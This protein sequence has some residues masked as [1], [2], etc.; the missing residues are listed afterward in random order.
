ML[1]T[2]AP[3]GSEQGVKMSKEKKGI[4]LFSG[5]GKGFNLEKRLMDIST[6]TEIQYDDP[7]RAYGAK[8]EKIL[9]EAKMLSSGG[10]SLK[11]IVRAIKIAQMGIELAVMIRAVNG[12]K[13]ADQAVFCYPANISKPP[14]QMVGGEMVEAKPQWL[15]FDVKP[16]SKVKEAKMKLYSNVEIEEYGYDEFGTAIHA[17]ITQ[18]SN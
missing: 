7:S 1:E 15:G 16:L 14:K 10:G 17:L 6:T 5:L 12:H 13:D 4:E 11:V 3:C 9:E 18:S 2:I 8:A